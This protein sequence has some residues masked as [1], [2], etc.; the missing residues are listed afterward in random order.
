MDVQPVV[1]QK[2]DSG[3][4]RIKEKRGLLNKAEATEMVRENILPF[5]QGLADRENGGFYGEADF[6]G[7]ADKTAAKGSILHARILWAFS[8]A[9]GIFRDE[10]YQ[11][12]AAHA[13]EF[14]LSAFMD[15]R[16]GGLYWLADHKGRVLDTRKQ[17]YNIAFGIYALSEHF[18][19]SGDTSS[20][21]LAHDLFDAIEAHG[22][23][24]AAGG[25]IEA[26]TCEWQSVNDLRLSDKDLNS[27]KSMN[28]NLHVL[29]A[30]TNLL[31]TKGDAARQ[32]RVRTALARLLRV[33]LDKIVNRKHNFELFFD[34]NWRSL[35]GDK[36]WGHDIEGSWLMY[37]AALATGDEKLIAEAKQAALHI[38]GAVYSAAIDPRNGGLLSGCD[39]A[40][41]IHSKKEWWPQ[42]EAVVGFFNAYELSGEQKYYDAA[43]GIWDF[44]QNHF[45]DREHGEWHNELSLD[46][47]PDTGMPKAGFWKCPYHNSRACFE[48]IRRMQ[49]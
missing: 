26:C 15:T 3:R 18:R 42:A 37:E 27:P 5:W 14:L 7:K 39:A 20:L 48:L 34:M 45:T 10:S 4:T 28:T 16:N 9:Y 21:N 13:K 41:K 29:E 25:Y 44:I 32:Q 8:A 6:Y 49:E 46:N 12:A 43:A 47:R 17:F 1:L 36:S 22:F 35:T 11:A 2:T 19:A 24:P 31:R 33:T 40:G 38:A 23:D 30:Y